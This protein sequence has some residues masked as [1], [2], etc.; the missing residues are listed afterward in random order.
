MNLP[1]RDQQISFTWHFVANPATIFTKNERSIR[2]Q[3][4]KNKKIQECSTNKKRT[5]C[6]FECWLN[7]QLASCDAL[8]SLE[9]KPSTI[10]RHRGAR[11]LILRLVVQK[12]YSSK[13][14]NFCVFSYHIGQTCAV[15][16]FS[17]SRNGALRGT[18][19]AGT[20]IPYVSVLVPEFQVKTWGSPRAEKHQVC[21]AVPPLSC[22][23]RLS[24][25]STAAMT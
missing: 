20:H 7:C 4:K 22:T 10:Q 8:P 3:C 1:S 16:E 9:N 11:S 13:L 24:W 18:T 19:K 25:S 17:W 21:R 2:P 15:K 5:I 6:A 23:D 12:R 14:G